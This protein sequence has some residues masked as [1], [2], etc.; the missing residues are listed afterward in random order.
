VHALLQL[1]RY[2]AGSE[3]ITLADITL[4]TVLILF[5]DIFAYLFH[6]NHKLI[7]AHPT[8]MNYLR[9]IYQMPNVEETVDMEAMKAFYYEKY[10]N[11]I[12]H[13]IIPRGNDYFLS[14][15]KQP[16]N[17]ISSIEYFMQAFEAKTG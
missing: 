1:R 10:S 8:I 14:R 2:I 11:L 16:H 17:R 13:T 6:V 4:F 5:D 12:G 7:S 3:H 15:L 9:E